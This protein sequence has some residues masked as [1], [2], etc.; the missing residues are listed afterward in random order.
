[1]GKSSLRSSNFELLRIFA[2]LA[3]IGYHFFLQ[4]AAYTATSFP[5]SHGIAMFL[6]S[7]GR[8][9]VNVFVIIGAWFLIDGR[10]SSMR[11]IRLYISCL[12]YATVIT[13][14]VI[15]LKLSSPPLGG[16][17]AAKALLRVLTPFSSSPLWFVTD[18]LFLLLLSPFLNVFI[19]K[20]SSQ[21]YRMLYWILLIVFVFVPTVES[22]IPGFGIYKYYVVKSDIMCM[23][24]LYLI[25][26]YWKRCCEPWFA[27][28]HR[29]WMCMIVMIICAAVLCIGDHLT[30]VLKV[31]MSVGK[32]YH[33]FLEYLFM[34]LS[35]AFSVVFA[36]VAFFSFRQLDFS[37][38]F[39]NRV[40]RNTLGV[41]IIH[42]TPVFIPVMWSVFRVNDMLGSKCFLFY[43]LAVIAVVFAGCAI[44]DSLASIVVSQ[45]LKRNCI[46]K[47]CSFW[48]SH[49]NSAS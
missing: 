24:S 15:G 29:P 11:I 3:I 23:I 44:I 20:V 28:G 42:Q 7:F 35:S 13:A 34:D 46:V 36:A 30:G 18:Y 6:G 31:P 8:S 49:V 25:V 48:D 21:S 5:V 41:Y 38:S 1:M 26:G 33:E 9:G 22:M 40:A 37:S 16:G 4:T 14:V 17:A 32:K 10:F 43:E 12:L 27:S 45:V 47:L 19:S 39:V 2:M